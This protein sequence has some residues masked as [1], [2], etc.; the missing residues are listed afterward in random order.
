MTTRNQHLQ[1]CYPSELYDFIYYK[2]LDHPE[3]RSIINETL[4]RQGLRYD[5][6][7]RDLVY[8]SNHA[9]I[10][11]NHIILPEIKM[12]LEYH[13]D[14][15]GL[16]DLLDKLRE[17]GTDICYTKENRTVKH[18]R[19]ILLNHTEGS[20]IRLEKEHCTAWCL[21]ECQTCYN[22]PMIQKDKLR[23]WDLD[24]NM[25]RILSLDTILTVNS[26]FFFHRL[27]A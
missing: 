20:T 11:R 6:I 1:T 16:V 8:H 25:Y 14:I 19:C 15:C 24:R 4:F 3:A 23:V 13:I 26:E 9:M 10:L 27:K 22:V 18:I 12:E 17:T 21:A 7:T 5:E 2:Y